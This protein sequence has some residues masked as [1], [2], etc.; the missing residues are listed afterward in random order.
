MIPP[1]FCRKIGPFVQDSTEINEESHDFPRVSVSSD[2]E[3]DFGGSSEVAVNSS[4]YDYRTAVHTSSPS[5]AHRLRVGPQA[6]SV[7]VLE[8]DGVG[9]GTDFPTLIKAASTADLKNPGVP[10]SPGRTPTRRR[11]SE[12]MLEK[13]IRVLLEEKF[14][15]T[16]TGASLDK[17][18]ED[19][20]TLRSSSTLRS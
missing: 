7:S 3:V 8:L 16:N 13:E 10:R 4:D 1:E 18:T 12:F 5:S 2:G 19:P 15:N 17:E 11:E 9:N 6:R 14:K 20:G